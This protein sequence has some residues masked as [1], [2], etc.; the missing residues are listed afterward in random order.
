MGNG[1]RLGDL[2]DIGQVIRL[3]EAF[4]G[5]QKGDMGNASQCD[6]QKEQAIDPEEG[7][8]G[9]GAGQSHDSL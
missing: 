9:G 3:V 8:I 5:W 6:R 2:L 7:L 4:E 1:S